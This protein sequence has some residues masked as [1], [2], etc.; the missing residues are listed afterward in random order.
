MVLDV[1]GAND[2]A[3]AIDIIE[4]GTIIKTEETLDSSMFRNRF[5]S[6]M[7]KRYLKIWVVKGGQYYMCEMRLLES[8]DFDLEYIIKPTIAMCKVF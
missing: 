2:Q 4:N 6:A 5:P 8:D 3:Q 7:G 1:V